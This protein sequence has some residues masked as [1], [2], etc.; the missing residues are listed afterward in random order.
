[1]VGWHDMPPN[2]TASARKVIR[3]RGKRI[4]FLTKFQIGLGKSSYD[5]ENIHKLSQF[6]HNT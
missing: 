5:M 1:M 6:N 3:E 4:G 2:L